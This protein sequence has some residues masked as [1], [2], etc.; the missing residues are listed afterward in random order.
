MHQLH[1]LTRFC[2][3][4][5]ATVFKMD[6]LDACLGKFYKDKILLVGGSRSE[7]VMEDDL[8]LA[9]R[10]VY[11]GHTIYVRAVPSGTISTRPA[12]HDIQQTAD[13]KRA[14]RVVTADP[15]AVAGTHPDLSLGSFVSGLSTPGRPLRVPSLS[16][17]SPSNVDVPETPV[18]RARR[19]RQ[20]VPTGKAAALSLRDQEK[21]KKLKKLV[22]ELERELERL[23][24]GSAREHDQDNRHQERDRDL[25]A[26]LQERGRDLELQ[27]EDREHE[28]MELRRAQDSTERNE[29][30]TIDHNASRHARELDR[31]RA[32]NE[33]LYRQL[34][35]LDQ[36]LIQREDE[37]E[38]PA[39]R[40]DRLQLEDPL[41]FV[42]LLR[43]FS[44][45]ERHISTGRPQSLRNCTEAADYAKL[46]D[47]LRESISFVEGGKSQPWT[48]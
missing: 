41:Y 33:E 18:A 6:S 48:R 43:I 2:P 14:Q 36:L 22:F 42:R 40:A 4:M 21:I 7:P 23:Q 13:Q 8:K 47:D 26:Q 25:V 45:Y 9:S 16:S 11:N 17:P 38:T 12:Y 46:W 30:D 5:Y 24:R 27:L 31:M 34:E 28:I 20:S 32:E 10:N 19:P 35:A 44:R 1:V 39:D 15:A 37:V 29:D 3:D